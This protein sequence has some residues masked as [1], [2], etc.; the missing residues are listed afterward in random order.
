VGNRED[1][2]NRRQTTGTVVILLHSA[3]TRLDLPGIRA[4]DFTT[5][6]PQ[7]GGYPPQ[8]PPSPQPPYGYNATPPP[9]QYGGYQQ[10]CSSILRRV[11]TGAYAIVDTSTT[12]RRL[13]RIQPGMK[14]YN[15]YKRHFP[16]IIYSR[17]RKTTLL[18]NHN[19][20]DRLH[21]KVLIPIQ[22]RDY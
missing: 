6:Q 9:Q 13:R 5:R 21:N 18:H 10:V 3:F 16:L 7:Y 17:L 20:E 12:T 8:A 14:G 11:K 22:L 15:K 4:A 19:M 1:T 2:V